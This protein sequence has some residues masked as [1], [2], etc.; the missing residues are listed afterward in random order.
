MIDDETINRL[1]NYLRNG[2]LPDLAR[3]GQ[4]K[5]KQKAAEF[6]LR[7]DTLW[8]RDTN[9]EVV[10]EQKAAE[11]IATRYKDTT[12]GRDRL[13]DELKRQYYGISIR[14]INKFLQSN[15]VQQQ[16]K[17]V[18]TSNP[19]T[20]PTITRAPNQIWQMDTTEYVNSKKESIWMITVID[21]FSKFAWVKALIKHNNKGVTAAETKQ[22]IQQIFEQNGA[23]SVLRTDNGV[24][25][26]GAFREYITEY[27]AAH[28]GRPQHQRGSV[29]V[30]NSQGAIERF[31]RTLKTSC[32]KFVAANAGRGMK[33]SPRV[34][35]WIVDQY[36]E[37]MHSTTKRRPVSLHNTNRNDPGAKQAAK[38]IRK[39]ANE[40]IERNK[41]EFPLVS[42]N[43]RVR[44][45]I[46]ALDPSKL[47][48]RKHNFVK[49]Y[50]KQWSKEI[51]TVTKKYANKY[52]VVNN[53][54]EEI[55]T[56]RQHLQ[57]V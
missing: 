21:C 20:Q 53:D 1:K 50:S 14:D 30:K 17:P 19:I 49:G 32:A 40:M 55:I 11:I 29:Y 18:P 41:R 54:G 37:S 47:S 51:Y 6:E 52:Q 22:F 2:Q 56:V 25:F 15:S 46:Y 13:F 24:E 39:R 12:N 4:W 3:S 48:D 44:V 43:D 27:A 36:N 8:H 34:V 33:V 9:R 7:G 26:E 5:F 28:G 16:F 38:R 31:N 45:S 42:V 10:N 57:K 23:P 35:E